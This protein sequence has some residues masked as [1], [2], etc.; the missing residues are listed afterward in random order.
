MKCGDTVHVEWVDV[1]THSGWQSN[2]ESLPGILV[3]TQG[4]FLNSDDVYLR[5]Y[6]SE[7]SDGTKADVTVIPKCLIIKQKVIAKS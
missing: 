6:Q 4:M 7:A 1:A 5:V 3:K 2:A